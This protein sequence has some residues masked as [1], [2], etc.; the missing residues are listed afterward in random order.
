MLDTLIGVF[1]CDSFYF[2]G[3]E[4]TL[5]S[6]FDD[7]MDM[8]ERYPGRTFGIITNGTVHKEKMISL[9]RSRSD[10]QIQVS[11]D[12]SCEEIN[13]RIRGKG[14]FEKT[15]GLI[16]KLSG[17]SKRPRVKMVISQGNLDDIEAFYK[18][19]VELGAVPEFSFVYKSGGACLD[20]AGME[21]SAPDKVKALL[22]IDALNHRYLMTAYVPVCNSI[23]PLSLPD[24]EYS[25]AIK[26]DG[27]VM[28]CQL[29]YDNRFSVG[30]ILRDPPGKL[31]DE[32]KR[33]SDEARLRKQKDFGCGRCIMRS[34]CGKG[35]MA[36]AFLING[37]TMLSDGDCAFR[38]AQLIGYDLKMHL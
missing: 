28:P 23:C 20:W 15:A 17:G 11:L 29:L 13:A 37:D 4:P 32:L 38:K 18:T 26:N 8:T 16:K 19:A 5:H 24:P 2:A 12:G 6:H 9:F 36:Q 22:R 7:L 21:V 14:S 33:I 31:A 27:S 30:N 34:G 25:V 1:D 10:F 3:G 35:C